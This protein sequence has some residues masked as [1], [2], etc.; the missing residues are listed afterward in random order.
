MR[1][2]FSHFKKIDDDQIKEIETY[3]NNRIDD[4]IELE[5][6]RNENY[7]TV[8]ENGAIGLFGENTEK[9]L[10]P[11]SLE[12]PMNYVEEHMLEIL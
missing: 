10:G 8:I 2:D 9:Q 3:V 11:L 1:F 6:N 4:S 5:E 12:I 7:N